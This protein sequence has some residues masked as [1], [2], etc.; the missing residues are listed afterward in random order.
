M[1]QRELDNLWFSSQS[2]PG[3]AFGLNDSVRVKSGE[4]AG[5]LAIVISLESLE[6]SPVYIIELGST[7]TDIKMAESDLEQAV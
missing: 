7:G 5:E 3:V 6:P 1:N 2:I 4:H